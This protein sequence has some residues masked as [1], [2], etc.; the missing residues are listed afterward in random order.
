MGGQS[1]VVVVAPSCGEG[2]TQQVA[3]QDS[4]PGDG[5][6]ADWEEGHRKRSHLG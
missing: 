3:G 6:V 1:A 2:G 5:V 4:L